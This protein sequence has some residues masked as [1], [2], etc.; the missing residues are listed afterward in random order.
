MKTMLLSESAEKFA[1]FAAKGAIRGDHLGP[2][3]I[4]WREIPCWWNSEGRKLHVT[5]QGRDSARQ[6]E[7]PV[8]LLSALL[9]AKRVRSGR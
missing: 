6:L 1:V 2:I 3:P 7:G 9:T 5:R 4:D 8:R